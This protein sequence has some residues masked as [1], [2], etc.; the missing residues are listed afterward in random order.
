MYMMCEISQ[1]LPETAVGGTHSSVLPDL[2]GNYMA[3]RLHPRETLL[4]QS[5]YP[6][7]FS[8]NVQPGIINKAI[9]ADGNEN[10]V[11][12]GPGGDVS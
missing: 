2:T 1:L 9:K 11:G 4:F 6:R 10:V 12:G 8:R 3:Q 5:G 7:K